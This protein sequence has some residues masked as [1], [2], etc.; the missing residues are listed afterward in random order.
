MSLRRSNR[1]RCKKPVLDYSDFDTTSHKVDHTPQS[2]SSCNSE[3]PRV[4]EDSVCKGCH[5]ENSPLKHVANKHKWIECNKCKG[6]WHINCAGVLLQDSEKFEQYNI[7]YTCAVCV[8]ESLK[9]VEESAFSSYISKSNVEKKIDKIL[10]VTSVL[11]EEVSKGNSGK[12]ETN[13]ISS[14]L[15]NNISCDKE[16]IIVIDNIT[17]PK[18]YQNSKQIK[19]ELVKH[20][21]ADCIDSA[22]SLAK[23]GISLHL[24][25]KKSVGNLIDSWPG[26]VFGGNTKPHLPKTATSIVNAYLRDVPVN[27]SI[28]SLENCLRNSYIQFLKVHRLIY[29]DT[30]KPMP[31]VRVTFENHCSYEVAISSDGVLIPGFKKYIKFCPERERRVTRCYNCNKF[32][33]IS[34]S[35]PFSH[36]CGNCGSEECKE[37]VCTKVSKCSNCGESH[38]ATSSRCPVFVKLR[39]RFRLS[40]LFQN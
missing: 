17:S 27:V 36:S 10:S 34:R 35:C 7:G 21:I 40:T 4:E 20:N 24:K 16:A 22:Y 19:S 30:R 31:I 14:A 29:T 26:E 1:K 28:Q 25:D 37:A 38:K 8:C 39:S 15:K 18:E 2:K 12:I 23:G 3:P 33:H 9:H 13:H 5:L 11:T 6:W 32:G